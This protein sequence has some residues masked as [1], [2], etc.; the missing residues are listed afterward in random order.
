[1][2]VF[3]TV[4]TRSFLAHARAL[5]R[6]IADHHRGARV[7]VL[8]VEDGS[9]SPHSEDFDVLTSGDVGIDTDRLHRMASL[10]DA[11]EMCTAHE[12][13]LF[14]H[15][16]QTTDEPVIYLDSD[17]FVTSRLE[18]VDDLVATYGLVLTPQQ[19]TPTHHWSLNGRRDVIWVLDDQALQ[20]YGHFNAG[21]LALGRSA[22]AFLRW[23]DGWLELHCVHEYTEGLSGNQKWLDC[24]PSLFRHFVLR[25]PGF[26]VAPWNLHERALTK[27]N[28]DY[29]CSG[30]PLRFFHFHAFDPLRPEMV[31]CRPAPVPAMGAMEDLCLDYGRRLLDSGYAD[32]ASTPYVFAKTASGLPVDSR[33]RRLYRQA[34]LSEPDGRAKPPDPFDPDETAAFTSWLMSPGTVSNGISRYL[35]DVYSSRPDVR[36]HFPDVTRRRDRNGFLRWVR[37]HGVTEECIPRAL[38]P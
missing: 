22:E 14:L 32:V 19:T 4:V 38:I 21:F 10:Y 24:V 17:I 25:H 28:G 9:S 16:L 23:W 36:A 18:E 26:N 5:A 33:M 29:R 15:L 37:E 8:I 31:V 34:L 1:V 12:P 35:A 3:C 2:A 27:A 6:S 20:Q 13:S 7:V 30:E 11:R